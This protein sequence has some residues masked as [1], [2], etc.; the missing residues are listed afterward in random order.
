MNVIAMHVYLTSQ[1]VLTICVCSSPRTRIKKSLLKN[2]K[3]SIRDPEDKKYHE[4]RLKKKTSVGSVQDPQ[5][6]HEMKG[7]EN[8][9]S[10]CRLSARST[11]AAKE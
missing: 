5:R 7:I 6:D 2:I 3:R 4:R 10:L 1:P 8:I 11:D 9:F